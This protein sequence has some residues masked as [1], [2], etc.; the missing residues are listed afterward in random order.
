MEPLFRVIAL[1]HFRRGNR[2]WPVG[3]A[4]CSIN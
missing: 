3:H 2:L 1:A 4:A